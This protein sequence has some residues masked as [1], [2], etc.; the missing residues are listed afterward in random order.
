MDYSTVVNSPD[1]D[2]DFW[3]NEWKEP[4]V[5][6]MNFWN[7]KVVS[8]LYVKF[9]KEQQQQTHTRSNGNVAQSGQLLAKEL[10]KLKSTHDEEL[11]KLNSLHEVRLAEMK[12][13][14]A[15]VTSQLSEL[16]L[17]HVA[18]ISKSSDQDKELSQ[19]R[20]DNSGLKAAQQAS[21]VAGALHQEHVARLEAVHEAHMRGIVHALR[22]AETSL[23]Q[24]LRE[25]DV[26]RVEAASA[27]ATVQS[28]K[29]RDEAIDNVRKEV[30]AEKMAAIEVANKVG[31]VA[32]A[33]SKEL[34]SSQQA[35]SQRT[36]T[37]LLQ[38]MMNMF[39][40]AEGVNPFNNFQTNVQPK[41]SGEASP[42]GA[43]Q[44]RLDASGTGFGREQIEHSQ[45]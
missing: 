14:H 42:A 8:A 22:K 28:V 13:A 36:N 20:A 25:R 39:C 32:M 16:T 7:A 26:A 15:L 37:A 10:E 40:R 6:S 12:S 5:I 45:Q 31:F 9:E 35:Y 29:S 2:F 34:A 19:V 24:A 23:E 27:I 43:A 21:V 18:L 11:L 4:L 44:Q 41:S 38:G 30:Q 17:A 33:D 3:G 1:E